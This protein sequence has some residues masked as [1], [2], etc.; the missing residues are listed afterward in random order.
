MYGKYKIILEWADD[1]DLKELLYE[2]YK[3]GER[4][5]CQVTVLTLDGINHWPE[6]QFVGTYENLKNL[7]FEYGLEEED[8]DDIVW[9]MD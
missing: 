3:L 6:V 4:Y 2:T 1:S 5:N 7:A 9:E 8:F